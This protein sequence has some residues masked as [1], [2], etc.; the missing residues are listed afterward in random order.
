MFLVNLKNMK[1]RKAF[2]NL[3][4]AAINSDGKQD[5]REIVHKVD[6]ALIVAQKLV[7]G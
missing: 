5:I 7:E 2:C 6:Q 4:M 3:A 1:Q